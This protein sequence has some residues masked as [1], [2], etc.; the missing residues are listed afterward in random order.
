[1]K[2]PK[3]LKYPRKPKASASNATL[4]NYIHKCAEVDKTN[5]KRLSE[6]E[7]EKKKKETLKR[8]VASIGKARKY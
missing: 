4:E 2:K 1:M 7:S 6:Y 3:S 5:K 8:K